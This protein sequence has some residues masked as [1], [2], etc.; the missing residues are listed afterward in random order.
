MNIPDCTCIALHM[1]IFSRTS[2]TFSIVTYQFAAWLGVFSQLGGGPAQYRFDGQF[3]SNISHSLAGCLGWATSAWPS[4]AA[5]T[6]SSTSP[7]ERSN[8]IHLLLHKSESYISHA[9]TNW[10]VLEVQGG[11]L[12]DEEQLSNK[13]I[14]AKHWPESRG[15]PKAFWIISWIHLFHVAFLI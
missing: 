7:L 13:V 3:W 14:K 9:S 8:F 15:R 2:L 6:S 11:G 10:G 5:S 4:T 12:P 1:A